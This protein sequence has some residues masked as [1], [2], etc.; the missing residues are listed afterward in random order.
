MKMTGDETENIGQSQFLK[1]FECHALTSAS[2]TVSS[3]ENLGM[4]KACTLMT[5]SYFLEGQCEDWT[6]VGDDSCFYHLGHW[7]NV[8]L[9]SGLDSR[10]RNRFKRK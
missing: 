2:Q 1:G 3:R 6:G 8:P 9:N 5:R 7:T 10:G 4:F